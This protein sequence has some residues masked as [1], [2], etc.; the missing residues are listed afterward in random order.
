MSFKPDRLG[1]RVLLFCGALAHLCLVCVSAFA[2][3]AATETS[4]PIDA[5]GGFLQR[6]GAQPR[7]EGASK[8]SP[9][10]R[11]AL[12]EIIKPLAK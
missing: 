9:D 10:A 1:R 6:E 4:Q 2:Q 7:F 8:L 12:S 3:S 5:T 11:M